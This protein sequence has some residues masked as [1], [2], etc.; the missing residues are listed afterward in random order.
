MKTQTLASFVWNS[1]KGKPA[2]RGH[3]VPASHKN[4]TETPSHYSAKRPGV[5]TPKPRKAP[6]KLTAADRRDL[7]SSTQHLDACFSSMWRR[8]V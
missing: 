3:F 8:A 7:I 2:A 1:W 4:A 6:V 5:E